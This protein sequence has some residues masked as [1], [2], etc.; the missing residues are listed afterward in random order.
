MA[1]IVMLGA[2]VVGLGTAM[3]LARTPRRDGARARRRR[4]GRDPEAAWTDWDRRGV[5]Q[6]RLPHMFLSRYRAIVDAELPSVAASIEKAGGLRFNPI[7]DI[8]ESV[9]GPAP[10]GRRGLR[11]PHP[12]GAP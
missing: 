12:G 7:L 1:R 2:G 8:P 11:G 10:R 5:N 6:F 4:T 9:R 3:L